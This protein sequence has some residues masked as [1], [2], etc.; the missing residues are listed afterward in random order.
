MRNIET[1]KFLG[2]ICVVTGGDF[3]VGSVCIPNEL[4]YNQSYTYA[5]I[6]IDVSNKTIEVESS[7]AWIDEEHLE[8]HPS[9]KNLDDFQFI[10]DDEEY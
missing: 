1:P 6:E 2:K 10:C 3:Q 8:L 9:I 5:C 4:D 7:F